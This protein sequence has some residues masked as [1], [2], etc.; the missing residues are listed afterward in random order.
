MTF[1]FVGAWHGDALNWILY[2]IYHGAGV[3]LWLL[4]SQAMTRLNPD[5]YERLC[6]NP[7]YRILCT[8]ATTAFVA[9]GL[10]LTLGMNSLLILLGRA[11][12]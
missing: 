2:G 7:V 6:A 5:G 1:F 10:A 3:A 8:G 11:F 12:Y 4:Y 9:A